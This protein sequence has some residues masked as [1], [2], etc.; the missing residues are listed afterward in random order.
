MRQDPETAKITETDQSWFVPQKVS[1]ERE[2]ADAI[3]E[4]RQFTS[5]AGLSAQEVTWRA[6]DR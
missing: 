3:S 4:T 5:S 6:C 2:I 1:A